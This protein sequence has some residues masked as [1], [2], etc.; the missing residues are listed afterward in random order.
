MTKS[1][2]AKSVLDFRVFDPNH[3]SSAA[4]AE[5][6]SY[7]RYKENGDNQFPGVVLTSSRQ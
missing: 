2:L 5:R 7:Y 6:V 3:I 1:A 4:N